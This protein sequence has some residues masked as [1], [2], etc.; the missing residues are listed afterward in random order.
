[1]T[2]AKYLLDASALIALTVTD[3]TH[4]AAADRW[5]SGKRTLVCP[6]AEGALVQFL[7]RTGKSPATIKQVLDKIRER[8]DWIPDDLSY[9]D[10]DFSGITG[11]RQVTD[12]YLL[13]LARHHGAI[14]AT[15]DQ[16][17]AERGGDDALLIPTES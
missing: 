6:V 7:I 9:R 14:L 3:H 4:F 16:P 5:A 17:L 13:E 8:S 1:M 2:E 10:V 15:F 11:H 12:T